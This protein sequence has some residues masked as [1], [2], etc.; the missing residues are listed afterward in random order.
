MIFSTLF[1]LLADLRKTHLLKEFFLAFYG[2]FLATDWD[3]L[4]ARW[5]S[6]DLVFLRS[7]EFYL[8]SGP[9]TSPTGFP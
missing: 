6:Y 5:T 9:E 8:E 1:G 4:E 3:G 2:V 7:R